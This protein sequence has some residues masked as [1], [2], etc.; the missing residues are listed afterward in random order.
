VLV[1]RVVD[2]DTGAALK[3]KLIFLDEDG[4]DHSVM[5]S[6]KYRTLLPAGKDVTIIVIGMSPDYHSQLPTAPLRLE[7]GQE[8]QMDIPLSKQ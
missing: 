1:G 4:H 5:V 3:A 2:A 6:G 7:A 8:M